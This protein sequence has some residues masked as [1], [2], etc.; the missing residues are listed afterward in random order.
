MANPIELDDGVEQLQAKETAHAVPVGIWA[1]FGGLV[2]WGVYYFIAFIGWDQTGELSGQSTALGT[3]VAH[4]VAY[5]AIPAA[6]IVALAVGM[7]RRSARG[8]RK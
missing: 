4:T 1:L 7:A 8:K 6:A 2:A 5:T 3:N